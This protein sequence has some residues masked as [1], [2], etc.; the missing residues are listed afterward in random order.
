MG[1]DLV[2]QY[3]SRLQPC[4]MSLAPYQ[5]RNS[6]SPS[7]SISSITWPRQLANGSLTDCVLAGPRYGEPP[8]VLEVGRRESFRGGELCTQIHGELREDL[9]A[10]RSCLLSLDD[11]RSDLPVEP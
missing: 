3:G 9:A 5:S 2:C 8:H 11:R 6:A 1:L 10:P 7:F 4:A